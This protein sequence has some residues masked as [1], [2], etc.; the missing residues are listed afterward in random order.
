MRSGTRAAP[1]PAA[2]RPCSG[3]VVVGAKA[4]GRPEATQL[5]VAFHEG[6]APAGAVADHRQAVERAEARA[7]AVRQLVFGGDDEDVGVAHQLLE[8]ER[9]LEE[10]EHRER[11]IELATL[12][13]PKEV[14]VR[15]GLLQLELDARP[16]VEEAAHQLGND[17]GADTLEGADPEGAGLALDERGHV[18]LGGVQ[19][20]D[21]RLGVAEEEPAGLGQR[22]GS[23]PARP[24]EQPLADDPL[25]GLDLLADRRLRIAERLR[26]A[27]EGALARDSLERGQMPHLDP[28]PP[29]RRSIRFHDRTEHYLD[30]CL[31]C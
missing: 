21:D 3:A 6:R 13:E 20:R 29:L 30:L 14:V 24:L 22:Y 4:N 28:Q 1:R 9:P 10:R 11:Q 8:L 12:D 18:G 27:A 31:C 23:R 7:L 5:E 16:G 17:L 15:S 25:K 2:T 19:P 26:G